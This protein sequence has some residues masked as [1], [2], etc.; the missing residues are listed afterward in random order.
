MNSRLEIILTTEKANAFWGEKAILSFSDNGAKIHLDTKMT[1]RIVQQAA[2]KIYSQGIKQV[3]L[4]G[5]NWN[6]DLCWAFAQGFRSSTG[7]LDVEWPHLSE[8]D[9]T[10]LDMWLTAVNWA[11][12]IINLPSLDLTPEH[13]A[14][15]CADLIKNLAPDFVDYKVMKGKD[16]LDAGWIGTYRVGRGSKHAPAVLCL[17]FNPTG[18]PDAPVACVFVGKGITF[19]SGGYSL[20]PARGMYTMHT[21]MGGAA[22]ASAALALAIMEG[23]EKRVKLVL[24]CAENLVSSKSYKVGDILTYRNG[25][26]VEV[27]NTDAEGRLVLA[28]GLIYAEEQNPEMIIDCATLTGAA[29]VAVGSDYHSILGFDQPLI[30]KLLACA[31]EKGEGFWQLPLANFH[32][33]M[34]NSDFAD[35][36]NIASGNNAPGASSA[37]AFL[38]HFLNEYEKGWI[39]VDCSAVYQKSPTS[40]WAC[41]ATGV[42]VRTL[43]KF[44]LEK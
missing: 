42:G 16:L 39:H 3:T 12:D 40:M 27:K 33:D 10:Q 18:N 17:D 11:R 36:A 28:D 25:K 23:L 1:P 13:L 37:A 22:T 2:R 14:S 15:R 32:R 24:C 41:G 38:S 35:L 7:M 43:A 34:L 26:T 20:K 19:D 6:L 4:L 44:V 5:E 30:D 31:H 9:E 29:K 21:D 8:S